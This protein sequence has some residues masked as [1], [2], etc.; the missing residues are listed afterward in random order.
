MSASSICTNTLI[1]ISLCSLKKSIIRPK[2]QDSFLIVTTVQLL[3]KKENFPVQ[4]TTNRPT[5]LKDEQHNSL[6]IK[7]A[8]AR[9]I[10]VIKILERVDATGDII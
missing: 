4:F 7:G 2:E 8:P 5:E 3:S 9:D 6:K 1:Q 10:A